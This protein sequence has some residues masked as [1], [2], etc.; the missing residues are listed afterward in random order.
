MVGIYSG[1][2]TLGAGVAT[3][4]IGTFAVAAAVGTRLLYAC[5]A[6]MFTVE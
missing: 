6:S 2:G 1:V 3:L 4:G 5:A